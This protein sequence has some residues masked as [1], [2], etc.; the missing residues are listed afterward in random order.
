[1]SAESSGSGKKPKIRWGNGLWR[2]NTGGGGELS[3]HSHPAA[4]TRSV[5]PR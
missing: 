2:C 3:L 4:S 5:W 1:M